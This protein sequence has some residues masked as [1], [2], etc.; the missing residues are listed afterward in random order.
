MNF[1]NL[2]YIEPNE[3]RQLGGRHYKAEERIDLY[4]RNTCVLDKSIKINGMKGITLLTNDENTILQSLKRIGYNEL[5]V[6]GIDF[7]LNVVKGIRF[8]SAHYK[9]DVFKY[10][11]QLPEDEY[12]ILLDS[13]MVC[14]N[15]FT[16]EQ[17]AIINEKK[18]LVYNLARYGGE[19]KLKDIQSI[20]PNVSWAVW[21]GGEFIGGTASFFTKLYDEIM[22]FKE[23]Y[24]KGVNNE[25]F[26]VGDEMLTTIALARLHDEVHTCDAGVLGFVHRYWSVHETKSIYSYSVP[27]IHLPGD[28]IFLG[29]VNL[30]AK[31][32]TELMKGYE[33]WHMMCRGKQRLK[34][35]LRK[36]K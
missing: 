9:I 20:D 23:D 25:L 5:V 22:L 21:V 33:L 28:K 17:L 11:S 10:F 19:K 34:T 30:N 32:V 2:L 7:S 29:K 13:D 36:N 18:P 14:L 1:Y 16:K 12:C 31:S 27:F 6:K 8:Y 35:V 3:Q 15:A 26:H 24:W 4:V